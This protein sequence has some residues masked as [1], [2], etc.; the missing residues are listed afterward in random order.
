MKTRVW[1][2]LL[3][4]GALQAGAEKEA[5]TDN[6]FKALATPSSPGCAV[7]VMRGGKTFYAK[8]YGMGD[9]EQG[10]GLSPK[11]V[12]YMGS[13][14]K[15]F[16]AFSILT[17]EKQGKLSLD[18]SVRKHIPELPAYFAPVTLRHLLHHT[19]GVRD[20]LTL[21]MLAGYS[22]D[23]VW[24][25]RAALRMIA[26]QRALNFEP[27]AEHL[28]SNSGYVL[29]AL[30]AQRIAG[31]RL[32]EWGTKHLFGPLGMASSRWQHNHADL[33]PNRA[34]G[35]ARSG[36]GAWQVS[37]AM[38]DTVGGGGMYS[39]VEDMLRWAENLES[40]KLGGDLLARMS[41][42]GRLRNGNAIPNGYG[43]GLVKGTYRGQPSVS[44]GGALAGYRTYL[45]HLP[46]KRFTVVCL[47]SF[48]SANPGRF[49]E[50]AADVWLQGEL[51]PA[52]KV[53]PPKPPPPSNLSPPDASLKSA[54]AGEWWSDELQA[55][56]RF[57]EDKGQF[58]VEIGDNTRAAVM[59]AGDG[60]LRV[61]MMPI[62]FEVKRDGGTVSALLIQAGRV[63]GIALQR[64]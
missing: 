21:G 19:G 59:A 23:H 37:D 42:P 14:S 40:G 5:E 16:M 12:F 2:I 56:Y 61:S 10:V 1:T 9:L 57:R 43:M 52:A 63:R 34:H 32:N 64:R 24:T 48:A 29:L 39:S 3:L 27:G 28:Y 60:S 25:E 11:S 33:V 58:L 38:V 62:T 26:R 13:V 6:L 31:E 15:Q 51:G 45:L 30:T 47:C 35:Y 44:H 7:G 8:G 49:A 50:Q 36:W 22:Q 17:M 41:E 20:Y 55:V 54:I 46:E 4:A 53:E 18:D